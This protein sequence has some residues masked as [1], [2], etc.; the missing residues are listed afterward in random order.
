MSQNLNK[1][2]YEVQQLLQ[3]REQITTWQALD[4][5]T[6]TPVILK[7]LDLSTLQ[8]WSIQARF[9][10]EAEA[11]R[12]IAHPRIPTLLAYE[13]MPEQ[14]KIIMVMERLPGETLR[15]RISN[16]WK[17]SEP[18]ARQLAADI[19]ELLALLHQLTPPL[20][21]RD[22]KPENI[23]IDDQD[24][25]YLIDLGAVQ[26]G[27]GGAYTTVGSFAYM[28]PEQLQGQAVPAT[29]QYGL[30]IA[31]IELLSGSAPS[32]I[33]RQGLYL[34]LESALSVSSG[35]RK[36]L[37]HLVAPYAEQRFASVAEASEALKAP[38]YLESVFSRN[39]VAAVHSGQ[40]LTP[41][42]AMDD[43][44]ELTYLRFKGRKVSLQHLVMAL[45]ATAI[46][47]ALAVGLWHLSRFVSVNL[48]ELS[49]GQ[50]DNLMFAVQGAYVLLVTIILSCTRG[51]TS[52]QHELRLTSTTL[53]HEYTV[54]RGLRGIKKKSKTYPL[55]KVKQIKFTWNTIRIKRKGFPFG[56]LR[57]IRL[58]VTFPKSAREQVSE[59]FKEKGVS[60]L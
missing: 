23:L 56:T 6:Q 42:I 33:P 28:A 5:H 19:L 15:K 11:L 4:T 14:Q 58:T 29:D 1:N 35:F 48:L 7:Q 36:W 16:G 32:A 46:M 34:D 3:E 57:K 40:L 54:H 39:A 8:D 17:V 26:K 49:F 44:P 18:Q 52:E 24:Q 45:L 51:I 60:V 25:V 22:I 37:E 21:H 41:H 59:A 53:T 55:A 43:T 2:R 13:E 9:V 27:V 31:L 30:G 20:I 38:E 50:Q 47:V 10:R 12:A